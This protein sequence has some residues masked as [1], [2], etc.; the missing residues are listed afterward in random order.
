MSTSYRND[1]LK[2]FSRGFTLIET[3]VA[4]GILGILFTAVALIFQQIFTETAHSRIR[5]TALALA[6]A[7]MEIV[8]N[9]P[10][11]DV[12]V[13]GG[14]PQGPLLSTENQIIDGQ[15]FNIQTSVEYIDDPFDDITPVDL[16]NTDYKRAR[17]Q[18]T[19]DGAY[20]S[21]VPVTMVTNIVPKGLE[22]AVG[23]G[24]LFI[25]VF[26]AQ[27]QP[28]SNATVN[29]N[30]TQIVPEIHM[31]T[32]TNSNGLVVLPGSPAC[33]NCYEIQVTKSGFSS[34]RTYSTSEVANPLQPF[35]T[36]LEGQISSVSFSIDR[37]SS[38][39]INSFG[40]R[41]S[42]FPPVA[43]VFFTIKGSKII[44]FDTNDE[45]VYKYSQ[46]KNTGG[47]TVTISGLEWDTYTLDFS[48]SSHVLTGS[49]PIS[50][51]GLPPAVNQTVAI[52]V[53]PKGNISLLVTAKDANNIP[54]ASASARLINV[55]LGIDVTRYTGATG[56]ADFGQAF[57]GS[58]APETYDLSLNLAGY[59]EATTSVL[60]TTNQK[61]SF[62]LTTE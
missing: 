59:V 1:V 28:I 14:I 8:R 34:S 24:T 29:I 10:Y 11:E 17:V 44:G 18:I 53:V 23:G 42:G 55:P 16:I 61:E 13:T 33:V 20:P 57:F 45:P 56:A 50:P 52:S 32:L 30:N 2:V 26:D 47:G 46:A 49:N 54:L 48:S 36:V 15:T 25:Q 5:S 43:N 62:T 35:A 39:I 22:S 7:K 37:I 4:V 6:T 38:V 19:W 31:Q 51:F 60:L 58:Y 27:S 40:S 21:R 9:L 12:G 41:E 3:L